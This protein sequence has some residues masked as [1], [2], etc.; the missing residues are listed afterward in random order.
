M[1]DYSIEEEVLRD[2]VYKAGFP[3][4]KVFIYGEEIS[5]DV[6]SVRI[7][8]SGGSLERSPSTVSISLANPMEKYTL[9]HNDM[10]YVGRAKVAIH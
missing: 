2:A 7:N 6:M 8:Q 1:T 5:A 10:I 3:A 4:Y 9:T